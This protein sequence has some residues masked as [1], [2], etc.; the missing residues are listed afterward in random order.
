MGDFSTQ[1]GLILEIFSSKRFVIQLIFVFVLFTLG[2][3][4]LLGIPAAWLFV[5]QTEVQLDALVEQSLQTTVALLDNQIAQIEN[6]AALLAERPTMNQL[7]SDE[8]L[9]AL[10]HYLENILDNAEL[11]S[12]LVCQNGKKLIS[13]GEEIR[14]TSCESIKT[15]ELMD[16]GQSTWLLT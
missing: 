1:A 14:F 4:I 16:D 11:D 13:V 12:I 10:S 5:R 3:A 2:S 8:E 15:T 6:L 7:I 9:P